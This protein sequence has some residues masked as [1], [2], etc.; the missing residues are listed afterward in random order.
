MVDEI[1]IGLPKDPKKSAEYTKRLSDSL[2]DP[3]ALKNDM[4]LLDRASAPAFH[5][6]VNAKQA[7]MNRTASTA[8]I[9]LSMSKRREPFR[10]WKDKGIPFDT[11]KI[12]ELKKIRMWARMFY[13]GHY[14]MSSIIN[15]YSRIPIQGM[16]LESSDKKLTDFYEQVFMDQLD[17]QN[18]WLDAGR[19]LWCIGEV[20][21]LGQFDETLG[22]WSSEE[23]LNP[24]DIIINKNPF[25]TAPDLSLAIPE[26]IRNI[27]TSREP[28]WQYQVLADEYPEIVRAVRESES[29]IT[30]LEDGSI[31]GGLGVSPTLIARTVQKVAPWDVYGTPHM[32]RVFDLLMQEE[33]L[34]SAQSACADRLYSPMILAKLGGDNMLG[35]GQ[36]WIPTE[37]DLSSFTSMMDAAFQGDFRLLT[38]HYGVDVKSVFGRESVPRFDNDYDRLERKMLQAWGVGAE[39][40]SGGQGNQ[41]SYASSAINRDFFTQTLATT[42]EQIKKHYRKRALIVAEAQGHFEYRK[43]GEERFPVYEQ[44]KK[45]DEETGEE[46]IVKRPKLKI[47]D[48]VFD[49]LNLK[50]QAQERKFLIDL[51]NGGA[52]VSDQTLLEYT[53]VD[54]DSELELTTSE[55]ISKAVEKAEYMKMLYE[56]LDNRDLLQYVQDPDVLKLV[57]DMAT[58]DSKVDEDNN[59]NNDMDNT[60]NNDNVTEQSSDNGEGSYSE[61]E[62]DAVLPENRLKSRPEVSDEMRSSRYRGAAKLLSGPSV[63]GKRELLNEGSINEL[64]NDRSWEKAISSI[65]KAKDN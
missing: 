56:A 59:D 45:V 8:D 19:E 54:F 58:A 52:P 10:T 21:S 7:S 26:D 39:L 23:I 41:A 9:Q 47:P 15:I 4:S 36:P 20:T 61:N 1:K 53:G 27:V 35:Q 40:L 22:I 65:G 2:A 32:L 48:M 31:T 14:L 28:K 50:D 6:R 64:I 49:T 13:M 18:F 30:Q 38:Y 60:V 34:N 42:Q 29:G 44:V 24:D 11:S 17:Y 3:N 43:V 16:R 55:K 33:A 46:Y 63:I 12:D 57:A 51:K 25:S 37:D 5:S 62:E